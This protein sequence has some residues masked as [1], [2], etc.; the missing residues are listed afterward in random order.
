M[1]RKII[2][3]IVLVAAVGGAWW[4]WY[5]GQRTQMAAAEKSYLEASGTIEATEYAVTAEVGG[6]VEAV[7]A[8]EGDEVSR[9]AVLVELD[10]SLLA[11]QVVQAEAELEV[12]QAQ[13]ALAKMETQAE[14]IAQGEAAVEKAKAAQGMA[15]QALQDALRLRGDPQEIRLQVEQLKTAAALAETAVSQ[16]KANVKLAEIALDSARGDGSD[17]GKTKYAVAEKDLERA[18]TEQARAEV[19]LRKARRQLADMEAILENPLELQT[20]VNQAREQVAVAQAGV[21]A[22]E[23]ALETLKAGPRLEDVA[24][25][26]AGVDQAEAALG[27]LQTQMEKLSL[28]SPTDGIV[29]SRAI[30]EGE[31]AQAGVSLLTLA[32][33]GEVKLTVYIP[34]DEIGQV[35]PG[36]RVMVEVDSYPGKE[37]PGEVVYISPEAEFTPKNVQ[38]KE[39]RVNTVFAVKVRLDNPAHELKPGMPADARILLTG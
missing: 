10:K 9:E 29:T 35:K 19:E 20:Q 26:Q 27:V 33:I 2:P 22:A 36:Q 24:V 3:L 38:T 39:E 14:V 4:W 15:E 6:R 34:E 8:D 18:R 28:H 7:L 37:Y 5:G 23:A 25:A 31:M 32:D 11:A 21:A 30:H 12:A 17:Q 16:A 1:I 13:L